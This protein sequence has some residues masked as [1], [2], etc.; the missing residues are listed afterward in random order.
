MVTGY[1]RVKGLTM[2]ERFL[3]KG[4]FGKIT[5]RPFCPQEGEVYDNRNGQSYM[6]IKVVS[7]DSAVME[8]IDT[9]WTFTAHRFY[10]WPD[11]FIEW[12]CSTSGRFIEGGRAR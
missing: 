2:R 5:A 10:L 11:G 4:L 1:H 8:N 12:G 6:C 7:P 3:K 9:G